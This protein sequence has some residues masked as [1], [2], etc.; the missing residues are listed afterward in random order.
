[1]NILVANN[2]LERVGGTETFTLTLIQELLD[3]GHNVEYFTRRKGR[4]SARIEEELGV[5]FKSKYSYDIVFANH[6]KIV[7]MLFFLTRSPIIQ[8]IHGISP[9]VEKPSIF[10]D[11]YVAISDEIRDYLKKKYKLNSHI[12]HNGINCKKYY[13]INPIKKEL[14]SVLSLA[15]SEKANVLIREVCEDLKIDLIEANKQESTIVNEVLDVINRVDMVVGIGRSAYDAMA[16]GRPVVIFDN[17]KYMGNKGDG[18]VNKN[19]NEILY[20]NCSGRTYNISYTKDLLAEEFKKYDREDGEFLRNYTCQNLNIEKQVE[21]YIKLK[22]KNRIPF[23]KK[24]LNKNQLLLLKF[25][26]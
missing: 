10:A 8:T 18:Y 21:K 5:C 1:M 6:S 23:I 14:K 19:I 11:S 7:R 26:A 15:Q 17:R 24:L 4:I 3:Q 20:N 13:A 25:K 9:K 16:C 2:K 12:I 22:I